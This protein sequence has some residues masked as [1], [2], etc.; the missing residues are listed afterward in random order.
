M[1]DIIKAAALAVTAAL[2]AVVVKKQA[3]EL[4]LVLALAAAG[5]LWLY[6]GGDIASFWEKS[7]LGQFSTSG[8]AFLTLGGR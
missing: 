1:T 8:A 7:G 5:A 4:G 3:R 6:T 2:C